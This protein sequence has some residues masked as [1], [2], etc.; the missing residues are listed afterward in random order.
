M[1]TS[2]SAPPAAPAARA[3]PPRGRA[4]RRRLAPGGVARSVGPARPSCSR[5]AYWADLGPHRR[6][7][8]ARLHD[9]RGLLRRSSRAARRTRRAH[10]PGARPARRRARSPRSLAPAHRAHRARADGRRPPTPSRS[11]S[12][13][14]S[15]RSTTSAT[16]A[17][18]WR[19]QVSGRAAEAAHVGRRDVPEFDRRDDARRPGARRGAL[20]RGR[21]TSVEVV[22]RLWDSWEDDAEIRDVATGRFIDRDKLHYVDFEGRFF[23]V[24]GPSIVPRP[25]QGQPVVA[26]LAHRRCRIEFAAGVGR[27]R[28]RDAAR[29]RTTSRDGSA[30]VRAAEDDG[31]PRRASRCASSPTSSSSSTTTTSGAAR[32]QA[33]LDELDRAAR[34]R[35]DAPIFTGTAARA[36]RPRCVA[37][38]AHGLDGF[39]LRPAWSATTSTPSSTDVVPEL[40]RRGLF[41]TSLRDAGRCAS[42]SACRPPVPNRYAGTR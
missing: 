31:R 38:Q 19:P 4:R 17:P 13:R 16:G 37:W 28:V 42:A 33:G 11:T 25:P 18:G 34:S 29:R 3:A 40:Q 1:T 15:P 2:P 24:Q 26:A 39:R 35:S 36:R 7:G 14:R 23:S 27:R 6:A 41:R 22:R 20:R 5:A 30:D 12:R 8:A 21:P 10:R 9:D 32:A